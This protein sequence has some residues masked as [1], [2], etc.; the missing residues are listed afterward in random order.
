M[1]K[2]HKEAR[3]QAEGEDCSQTPCPCECLGPAELG[4]EKFRIDGT[5]V[6][7]LQDDRFAKQPF[8][9][10]RGA[11][12]HYGV[13][14]KECGM[15][16]IFYVIILALLTAGEARSQSAELGLSVGVSAFND[17]G[18][19][20]LRVFEEGPIPA[21]L[22]NG[23]RIGA[24]WATNSWAFLGHEFSYAFQRTS[25]KIGDGPSD[26]MNV[27]NIYYNFVAHATPLDSSV[28]PFGTVGAGVSVYFPPGVASLSGRGD[29]NFGYNYG[30]GG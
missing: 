20:S 18:I 14:F 19:G 5:V 8:A 4:G 15:T 30:G 23:V 21:S 9:L 3:Q 28:R 7:L 10:V 13:L 6:D 11:V 27:Q 1:K 16:R 22:R 26:G 25:L 17:N 12:R 2:K 29:K 24:R